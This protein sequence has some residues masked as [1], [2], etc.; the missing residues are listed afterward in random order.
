[1]P[2]TTVSSVRPL[3]ERCSANRYKI[4]L[5]MCA[6][7][8]IAGPPTFQNLLF[9]SPI[10]QEPRRR[11]LR[12]PPPDN[13]PEPCVDT[14]RTFYDKPQISDSS[15]SFLDADFLSFVLNLECLFYLYTGK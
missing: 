14:A 1:M 13:S 3:K 7:I 4:I 2:D 9:H 10:R 15:L 5:T 8:I 12:P 11:A 6:R